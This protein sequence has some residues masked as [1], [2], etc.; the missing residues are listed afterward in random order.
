MCHKI[1]LA[2]PATSQLA[3]FRLSIKPPSTFV[4]LLIDFLS[5]PCTFGLIDVLTCFDTVLLLALLDSYSPQDCTSSFR[6]ISFSPLK[7]TSSR[8]IQFEEKVTPKLD[9]N[10]AN[11][12]EAC[13]VIA[14]YNKLQRVHFFV[15]WSDPTFQKFTFYISGLTCRSSFTQTR[16]CVSELLR[17]YKRIFCVK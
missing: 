13:S 11:R 2:F 3:S 9:C 4:M 15:S 14:R 1:C 8:R 16:C 17:K 7:K 5:P 12:I 6:E 10:E